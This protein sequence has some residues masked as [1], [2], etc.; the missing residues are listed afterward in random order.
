MH[1]PLTLY[2]GQ[3]HLQN[4]ICKNVMIL[5]NEPS[6]SFC[7][8]HLHSKLHAK[9]ALMSNLRPEPH[10]FTTVLPCVLGT[11]SVEV[12]CYRVA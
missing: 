5:G 4:W 8:T 11:Y 6:S 12:K 10:Q 2:N 9:Q 1:Q 3:T 7:Q